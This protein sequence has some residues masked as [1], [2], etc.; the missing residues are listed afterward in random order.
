MSYQVNYKLSLCSM[1]K[2]EPLTKDEIDLLAREQAN[3]HNELMKL[4]Y[5]RY[6]ELRHRLQIILGP[7]EVTYLKD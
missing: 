4:L 1:D 7:S 6:P 3:I 5:F 2:G